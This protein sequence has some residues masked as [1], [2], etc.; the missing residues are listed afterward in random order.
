MF[1]TCQD[2]SEIASLQFQAPT[3]RRAPSNP[4][5]TPPL[6]TLQSW[7]DMTEP[8][9]AP[10]RPLAGEDPLVSIVTP[11]RNAARFL[12]ETIQSVLSQDYPCID[13]LVMD[14]G[15]TD[16]TLD[17]LRRYGDRLRYESR[18]DGGQA[19][20]INRG[21]R[22]ARG[23]I[24]AYLNADDT[25]L[26]GAIRTAVGHLLA[27]PGIGVVYGEAYYVNREG[28]I[29][30][31]YPTAPFHPQLLNSRC[32][33]CQP[34]AFLRAE[35]FES[36]GLMNPELHF[37]LDYDLWM[38]VARRYPMLKVDE[39]L[40]TS[41]MHLENKTLG[42]RR[43]AY[44]EV[45]RVI[46]THYKYIPFDPVYG[47]CCH[48]VDKKDQFFEHSPPT[49]L[50]YGLSL[51]LGSWYN[52]RQPVRYWRECALATTAALKRFSNR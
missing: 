36:V 35:V 21:F 12:E 40:A 49:L 24:F 45:L 18:P 50:K 41:R 13:Y 1:S 20:A 11:C 39:F 2:P 52:R 15:S 38:R 10:A 4:P 8:A 27:N 47:Y 5:P 31:R 7:A 19:D 44:R 46:Y 22:L 3:G 14:G 48:L 34:A 37:A 43:L 23:R 33:I 30:R 17:L 28:Q 6:L 9:A 51:L 42:Q 16:D 32:Y 25:Y 26:P 29:L